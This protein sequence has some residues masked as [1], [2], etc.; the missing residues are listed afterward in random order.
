MR[1]LQF[2]Q[3]ITV[4]IQKHINHHHLH[5][6]LELD[7]PSKA[8]STTSF[9][10]PLGPTPFWFLIFGPSSRS[11]SADILIIAEWS[12]DITNGAEYQCNEYNTK[13]SISIW[14]HVL[15]PSPIS[16]YP[17]DGKLAHSDAFSKSP[18]KWYREI[19]KDSNW[20]RSEFSWIPWKERMHSN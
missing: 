4:G 19:L 17:K 7:Y 6:H 1:M 8:S 11:Q 12:E 15:I 10:P 18:Y 16:G 13:I 9:L 14:Y 20:I 5:L 3:L 2:Q